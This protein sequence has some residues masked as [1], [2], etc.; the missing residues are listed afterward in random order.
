MSAIAGCTPFEATTVEAKPEA[1]APADARADASAVCDEPGLVFRFTFD[2]LGGPT[3]HDCSSHS[4]ATIIPE[5][6]T[7]V[8]GV[9]AGAIELDAAFMSV[10]SSASLDV[11]GALTVAAWVRLGKLGDGERPAILSRMG[12][13]NQRGWE[14]AVT[15]ATPST[16]HRLV[17]HLSPDK[18]DEVEVTSVDPIPSTRWV[19]AAGVFEPNE[20]LRIYLDGVL[21]GA[22]PAP[23]SV[24]VPDAPVVIGARSYDYPLRGALDDVRFYARALSDA[25]I[26]TLAKAP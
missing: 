25:E 24:A 9:L 1:G 8:S 14:L 23:A 22:V 5:K 12:R 15:A 10:S 20:R 11:T 16:G 21:V 3:T 18:V 13:E 7:R 2:E 4:L 6:G 19:H 17:F 26:M